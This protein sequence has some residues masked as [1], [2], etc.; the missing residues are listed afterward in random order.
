MDKK[1]RSQVS[2]KSTEKLFQCLIFRRISV[3]KLKKIYSYV[4]KSLWLAKVMIHGFN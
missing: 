1:T 2:L 3:C 4:S